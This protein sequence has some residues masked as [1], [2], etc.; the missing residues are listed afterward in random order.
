[1][2]HC[3]RQVP[4]YGT[5]FVADISLSHIVAFMTAYICSINKV[6]GNED[7]LG[8]FAKQFT[9]NGRLQ[10]DPELVFWRRVQASWPRLTS[11]I[12][13]RRQRLLRKFPGLSRLRSL[14]DAASAVP[15]TGKKAQQRRKRGRAASLWAFALESVLQANF[16][17]RLKNGSRGQ[18]RLFRRLAALDNVQLL[19]QAGYEFVTA[20]LARLELLTRLRILTKTTVFIS[21]IDSSDGSLRRLKRDIT[22]TAQAL[23]LSSK[24][25]L[26]RLT[27]DTVIM[28]EAGCVLETAIPVLLS[29]GTKNLTLV[30][31]HNQLKPFSQVRDGKA[32]V[33]HSRSLMERA[34]DSGLTPQF[35]N[36]QYR[37]HPTI[38]DVRP[39]ANLNCP[40]SVSAWY[41]N[42][43]RLTSGEQCSDGV[44][45]SVL[46]AVSP[47]EHELIAK[48]VENVRRHLMGACR[49]CSLLACFILRFVCPKPPPGRELS[50]RRQGVPLVRPHDV[51]C[52]KIVL[53]LHASPARP[54]LE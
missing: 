12:S 27:I 17:K 21:T 28:D 38:C 25:K 35:L 6:F 1:M 36:T 34:I 16:D 53:H 7:R 19:L 23:R 44:L 5:Y 8:D 52:A 41:A 45:A 9:L 54:E 29:L 32:S 49:C 2:N 18:R 22:D 24:V 33:S 26:A 37:M 20:T 42:E 10:N 30:G 39:N 46:A 47:G 48:V 3:I 11:P 51:P 43:L 13:W 50:L 31:D 14:E 15:G 4:R 40:S